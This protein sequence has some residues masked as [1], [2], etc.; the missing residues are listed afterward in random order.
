M[1]NS[2]APF[3]NDAAL[4]YIIGY[5]P[6][7]AGASVMIAIYSILCAWTVALAVRVRRAG[8]LGRCC[9]CG[10]CCCCGDFWHYTTVLPVTAVLELLGYCERRELI[11]VFGA[12]SYLFSLMAILV[13]P[14]ILAIMNY[15]AVGKLLTAKGERVWGLQPATLSQLFVLVDVICVILQ[16]GGSLC[17]SL[18]IAIRLD[19]L[20]LLANSLLSS[21][22]AVQLALNAVFTML[23][24]RAHKHPLLAPDSS[25]VPKVQLF[26]RT[27]W[28]TVGLLWVR[29]LYRAIEGFAMAAGAGSGLAHEELFYTF[30]A[31]PIVVCC[32]A[33]AR[34]HFGLLLPS[35]EDLVLLLGTKVDAEEEAA[36]AASA[37]S[38]SAVRL[39][40]EA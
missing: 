5:V 3:N 18:S 34:A 6:S 22:F 15:K 14:V 19:L 9:G 21:S 30:E 7:V 25:P 12:W 40:D 23:I 36:A 27:V 35:D 26:W 24:L 33:H 38:D 28:T 1:S 2:T 16:F 39:Q 10:C 32:V 29:N 20:K 31:F 37:S 17:A 11:L 13:A 4:E 8:R